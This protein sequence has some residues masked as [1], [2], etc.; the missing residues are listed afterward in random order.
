MSNLIIKI[1]INRE[2][3]QKRESRNFQ[4]IINSTV[5][6]YVKQSNFLIASIS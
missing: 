4:K 6:S 1:G 2:I 5:N 3:N